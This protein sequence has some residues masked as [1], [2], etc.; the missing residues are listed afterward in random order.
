MKRFASAAK[1]SLTRKGAGFEEKDNEQFCI[2]IRLESESEEEE[3]E[4]DDDNDD[5]ADDCAKE[6]EAFGAVS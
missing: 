2:I 5:D 3:G 6:G 1:V 4:E